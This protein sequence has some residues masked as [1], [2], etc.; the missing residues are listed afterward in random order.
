MSQ[1]TT[2]ELEDDI[3]K[4]S[5]YAAVTASEL[6]FSMP[7]SKGVRGK[8]SNAASTVDFPGFNYYTR[9]HCK[10]GVDIRS[11]MAWTLMDNF[12]RAEGYSPKLGLYTVD[13]AHNLART[14][15]PMVA[16]FGRITAVNGLSADVIT[17]YSMK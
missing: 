7:G 4:H 14:P 8:W 10:G 13:R 1:K 11:Y 9:W 5:R 15:T 6:N 2:V 16:L 12:E 3:N 17:Q